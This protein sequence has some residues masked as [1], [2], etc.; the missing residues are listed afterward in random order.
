MI[1]ESRVKS[2]REFIQMAGAAGLGLTLGLPARAA[3]LS[4][5]DVLCR[6][7]PSTGDALP[8]IGVGT[9]RFGQAGVETVKQLLLEMIESG[10][11]VI[12]TAAIY[13]DSEAVIGQALSDLKLHQKMFVATKFNAAGARFSGPRGAPRS[14]EISAADSFERSLERLQTD[15]VDLLFAH[16]VSSVEPTMP[17]MLDLKES[18][19]TRYVGITSVQRSQH[20]EVMRYMRDF[21]IDFLQIDYS[22][23]NRDT[24]SDVLPLAVEKNIA[25]MVA[26][27]FG[28]RRSSLFA[29]VRGKTVPDWAADFGAETWGQFFLKY[30]ASHPAVTCVIPGT[31]DIEHMQ[32]N[33]A[34]GRGNLP[35]EAQRQ[36][37]ERFWDSLT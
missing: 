23:E 22:L 28:G 17:L 14:G 34:A 3:S 20:A 21:P 18:G 12:D 1:N 33:L 32:D 25:V 5:D 10:G 35:D 26:V 15:R 24:A 37:M 36:Q 9:N 13:G 4:C 8:V 29:K 2:R 19:R 27:P 16:F 30:V 6:Q 11:R 31:T 7:I